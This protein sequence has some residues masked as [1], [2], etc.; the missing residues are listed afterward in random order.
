MTTPLE[1][2]STRGNRRATIAGGTGLAVICALLAVSAVLLHRPRQPAPAV[3]SA[4]SLPMVESTDGRL[5]LTGHPLVVFTFA[6]ALDPQNRAD[7]RRLASLAPRLREAKISVVGVSVDEL[8]VLEAFRRDAPLTYPLIGEGPGLGRHP[9]SEQLGVFHGP[10]E[11]ADAPV[12]ATALFIVDSRGRLDYAAV[13]VAG[14]ELPDSGWR[15]LEALE[16]R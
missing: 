13:G 7:L 8:P 1:S 15:V 5:D 11:A 10:P 4:V 14:S 9:L 16:A 3:G 12:N 2:G 6:S